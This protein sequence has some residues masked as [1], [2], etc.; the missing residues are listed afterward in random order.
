[1]KLGIRSL[2]AF[3]IFITPFTLHAQA[4]QEICWVSGAVPIE[5]VVGTN[6]DG[7]ERISVT[8]QPVATCYDMTNLDGGWPGVGG[9]QDYQLGGGGGGGGSGGRRW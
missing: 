3:S 1:M 7:T 8:Y 5:T 9:D 4:S 2:I 6:P